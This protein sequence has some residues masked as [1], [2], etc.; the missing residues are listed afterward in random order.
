MDATRT[1]TR[2]PDFVAGNTRLR[3]RLSRHLGHERL[4]RMAGLDLADLT[5]MLRGTAYGRHLPTE[6][7]SGLPAD[8]STSPAAPPLPHLR[9]AVW[10]A[11][12]EGLRDALAA[13]PRAYAGAARTV[14]AALLVPYDV[15]DLVAVARSAVRGVDAAEVVPHLHGVGA[16]ARH[17]LTDAITD[18]PAARLTR[19][20]VIPGASPALR[21]AIRRGAD[22]VARTGDLAALE[23]AIADAAWRDADD[24]LARGGRPA[25]PV[26]HHLALRRD[27]R[28]LLAA[29][30]ARGTAAAAAPAGLFVLPGAIPAAA[31]A[32]MAAGAPAAAAVPQGWRAD[33]ARAKGDPNLLSRLLEER[34]AAAARRLLRGGDPL[35]A[36]V[37][38]GYVTAL[39]D[40][41]RALRRA[42]ELAGAP[43][44]R[45]AA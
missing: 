37:P 23:V 32:A 36:D 42:A 18:D 1:P 9:H 33:V 3:A 30:R 24:L 35:G 19:L 26:R 2:R 8:P 34:A 45:Q 4:T 17:D 11:V 22:A 14:V 12:Q 10:L 15:A 38:V 41:A 28:N 43:A 5:T 20:A 16:L 27:T 7:L 21:A 13:T 25:A 39:E 40:E 31:L 44:E 6:L 29:L